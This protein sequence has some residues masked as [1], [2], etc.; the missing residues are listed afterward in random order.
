MKDIHVAKIDIDSVTVSIVFSTTNYARCILF[1]Q[2]EVITT[3]NKV[4]EPDTFFA[5]SGAAVGLHQ[6]QPAAAEAASGLQ[7]NV[8]FTGLSASTTYYAYC[9]QNTFP[10][11][12]PS[13]LLSSQLIFQTPSSTSLVENTRVTNV[14]S[15]SV[16]LNTVFCFNWQCA[17]SGLFD[18]TGTCNGASAYDND[19]DGC[20]GRSFI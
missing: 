18:G 17:M 7:F 5:N 19:K 20:L 16:T 14:N 6:P 4:F 3:T 8:D 11:S 2:N 13:P 9:A 10:A 15:E 1:G 12:D